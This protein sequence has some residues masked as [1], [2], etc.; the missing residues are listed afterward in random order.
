MSELSSSSFQIASNESLPLQENLDLKV[1][2]ANLENRL[3]SLLA[4]SSISESKIQDLINSLRNT[5]ELNST[6]N[7]LKIQIDNDNENIQKLKKKINEFRNS[8]DE[9]RKEN[10]ELN[11]KIAVLQSRNNS[12][13]MD[14]FQSLQSLKLE[15][16]QIKQEISTLESAN[17]ELSIENLSLKSKLKDIDNIEE[18]YKTENDQLK[19]AN[20]GLASKCKI[21]E[22]QIEDINKQNQAL[23]KRIADLSENGINSAETIKAMK[24]Q[25]KTDETLCR[26]AVIICSQRAQKMIKEMSGL[27]KAVKRKANTASSSENSPKEIVEHISKQTKQST[28]IKNSKIRKLISL[29]SSITGIDTAKIDMN[30]I[31]S[32]Q[33][34]FEAFTNQIERANAVKETKYLTEIKNLQSIVDKQNSKNKRIEI[35]PEVAEVVKR[36]QDNIAEMA[37]RV[38]A[39]H[40]QLME[41]IDANSW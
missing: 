27:M 29:L 19:Q 18:Q 2:V 14:S 32:D 17:A 4:D 20:V 6:I 26:N 25:I 12:N 3:T 24:D 30:L 22:K 1:R 5:D 39:D 7:R 33:T 36:M 31:I 10:A 40:K 15:N 9:L 28:E 41:K 21:L 8:E 23:N 16:S 13:T 35:S 38:H 11:S 34:S 37:Q